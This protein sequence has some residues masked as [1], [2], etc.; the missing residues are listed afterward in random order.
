M[1]TIHIPVMGTGFSID[2]PIRV[3][4]FG[5]SSVM[6]IM[7]DMLIEKVREHYCK[8]F[9]IEFTPI[10]RWSKDS[11]AQRI[12]AYINTVREIVQI[13]FKEIKSLPF[14]E[15]NDK[16]KYF[17]MLP[18]IS[19]LKVAYN[20]LHKMPPGKKRDKAGNSL[21]N[22]MVK[23]SIDVNIMVKLEVNSNSIILAI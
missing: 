7:D 5:I 2:T 21:A 22:Q 1:H 12:T 18:D 15:S 6:S 9:N 17:K 10:A 8:K 4:P 11:R 20:R 19:P 3:A 13:K 14:F 23:G 16:E